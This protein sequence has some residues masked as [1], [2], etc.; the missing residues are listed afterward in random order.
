MAVRRTSAMMSRSISA[1]R[2]AVGELMDEM[3]T[4]EE[5]LRYVRGIEDRMNDHD[6]ALLGEYPDG[7]PGMGP[8]S[9][10]I[11][12]LWYL[13]QGIKMVDASTQY[14][15]QTETVEIKEETVQN[16]AEEVRGED[17]K[18]VVLDEKEE[19]MESDDDVVFVKCVN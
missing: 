15:E 7:F 10:V 16:Q 1:V 18:E 8:A 4:I 13:G 5:G 17:R 9:A 2:N 11:R 6:S 14:E 12:R 3:I 19:D